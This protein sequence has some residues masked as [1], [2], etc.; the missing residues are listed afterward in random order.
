[1]KKT[2]FIVLGLFVL[3]AG[4]SNPVDDNQPVFTFEDAVQEIYRMTGETIFYSSNGRT[5]DNDIMN[6]ASGPNEIP[7]VC[8]D[9]AI[10]FAYYWN[11]VK[12]YDELFGKAYFAW[13]PSNGSTFY[14]ADADFTP[15]GTSKIR[16]T[17]GN[18]GV[19]ANNTEMDGVYRDTI[20]TSIVYSG[21]NILHFGENINNHMWAV[22][23]IE[24][25]WYDCEPTWW[26]ISGYNNYRPYII[27]L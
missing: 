6:K 7:G 14:I 9:Y 23:K 21:K 4:C 27:S 18:F 8:T 15:D 1:M 22:I 19:N 13:V 2:V 5:M 26:D 10:E 24:D 12:D 11:E 16:E 3:F 25:D 17:S 20:V